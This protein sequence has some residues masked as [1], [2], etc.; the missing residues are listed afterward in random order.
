MNHYEVLGIRKGT[1]S[2]ELKNA[3]RKLVKQYHP[4]INPSLSAKDKI[5]LINEAYEVLSDYHSKSR[6]DQ[7]L[8]GKVETIKPVEETE[9]EKYRREFLR[10]RAREKREKFEYSIKMK[11]WFYKQERIISFLF[12]AIGLLFTVDYYF[13]NKN[14]EHKISGHVLGRN[15]VEV[16]TKSGFRFFTSKDFFYEEP[17]FDS[18]RISITYSSIFNVPSRIQFV[19]GYNQY[20]IFRN[21]HSFRNGFS[22][23]ILLFSGIVLLNKEYSDFRLSCGLVPF[24]ATAFLLLYVI[25]Y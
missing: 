1:T 7:F 23:I 12:F 24:F 11:V 2:L 13:L 21:L 14:I 20:R 18:Q 25:F 19:D 9:D 16:I 17:E 15:S 3:Y 4:D 8:D 6:Y 5:R 10:K 22:V